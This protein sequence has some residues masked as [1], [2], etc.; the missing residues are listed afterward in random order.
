MRLVAA[1]ALLLAAGEARANS[2]PPSTYWIAE[3]RPGMVQICPS[4][5]RTCT[6]RVLLRRD[7]ATGATVSMTTCGVDAPDC[8]VDEC[9]P[10]G[11]YQ[12]GFAVPYDC[13]TFG[14]YYYAQV[15]VDG[16]PAGCTRTQPEPAPVDSVPWPTGDPAQDRIC[17]ST[18]DGP[19]SGVG[20]STG[21]AVVGLNAL[22]ILVGLALRRRR[23][24]R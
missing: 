8:Y 1:I 23:V 15:A 22:A 3:T 9:V 13:S 20:C 16:A 6:D 5:G 19:G 17:A 12:Y 24:C 14:A 18:Y 2:A 11:T 7:V 4:V 21:G 10:A